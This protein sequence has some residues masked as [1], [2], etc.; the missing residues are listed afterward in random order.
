[1]NNLEKYASPFLRISISLVFLWFGITQV[2]SPTN[3]T[4]FLPNFILNFGWNP[5]IFIYLNAALE[6]ILGI[7]LLI[8]LFVRFSAF[9]LAIHLLFISFSLGYNAVAIRDLGLTLATLS[10]FLTGPDEYCL[11][12]IKNKK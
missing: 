5:E 4:S 12:K 2:I 11:D 1:M 9:I 8:G 6:I 3:W 10:I 7:F